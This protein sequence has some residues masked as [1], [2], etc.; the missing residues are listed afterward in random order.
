MTSLKCWWS[1]HKFRKV[2]R[3]TRGLTIERF[4][5]CDRCA[6]VIIMISIHPRY[7]YLYK[8]FPANGMSKTLY[9]E[10]KRINRDSL[11]A[12]RM[13]N[14]LNGEQ[15]DS[16]KHKPVNPKLSRTK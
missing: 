8:Q 9:F 13:K 11:S 5:E 2:G 12:I 16:T 6:K 15:D 14:N 1:G 7:N 4:V 3:S 10:R